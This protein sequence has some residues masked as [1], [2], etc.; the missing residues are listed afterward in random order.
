MVFKVLLVQ[1]SFIVGFEDKLG[2]FDLN[3]IK[4]KEMQLLGFVT[5]LFN[6]NNKLY[7][8]TSNTVK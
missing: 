3:F 2:I 6:F 1:D 8:S 4:I 7:V 5:K